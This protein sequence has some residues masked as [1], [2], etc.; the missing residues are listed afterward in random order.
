MDVYIALIVIA[1]AI[2]WLLERTH[3]RAYNT[4]PRAPF[5]ADREADADLS[6]IRHELEQRRQDERAN[7]PS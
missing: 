6:R 7:R 5:G 2:V 4:M 3:R 1:G